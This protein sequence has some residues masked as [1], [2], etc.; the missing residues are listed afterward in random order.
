ML[1]ATRSGEVRNADWSE[2]DWECATWTIPA[3]RMKAGKEH[4]IP[5]SAQAMAVL[6]DAR[7]FS[8]T[9]GLVIPGATVGQGTERYGPDPTDAAAGDTVN[10]S[11]VSAPASGI[12]PLNS[13]GQAGR[14]VSRHWP[15]P[16]G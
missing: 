6:Q 4:R 11:R 2:I 12:G 10:C 16:V 9:D 8:G 1:T 14:S 15:I 3:E 7:G 13:R 5:L